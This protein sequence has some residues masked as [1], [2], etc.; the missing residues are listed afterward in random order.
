VPQ[1]S[2]CFSFFLSSFSHLPSYLSFDIQFVDV[3]GSHCWTFKFH[4]IVCLKIVCTVHVCC[5]VFFC[6][7]RKN[8]RSAACSLPISSKSIAQHWC[9]VNNTV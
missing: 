9:P 7:V 5:G 1:L 3:K 8:P 6:N 2:L 4:I